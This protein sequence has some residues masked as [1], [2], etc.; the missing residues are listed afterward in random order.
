MAALTWMSHSAKETFAFGARLG[1]V[2]VPG[3][4]VCLEGPVGAGKTQ[5]ARGVA[6]GLGIPLQAVSSPTYALV[7]WYDQGRVPLQ[8][9]DWYRLNSE[10]DLYSTGYF[11]GDKA[12]TATL[13]EWPSRVKTA[14]PVD[15][16]WIFL[17]SQDPFT[18]RFEVA[19]GGSQSENLLK[20]W[21]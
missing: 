18:R 9:W 3:D 1:E 5:F 19:P 4:V 17:K 11:D 21:R 10:E 14:V 12:V 7:H 15:A 2:L 6:E 13:V 16:L 20:R 8:H